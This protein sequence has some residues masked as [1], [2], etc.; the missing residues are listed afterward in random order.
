[1]NNALYDGIPVSIE[2]SSSAP[3]YAN[4]NAENTTGQRYGNHT[5]GKKRKKIRS[6]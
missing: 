4:K 3:D 5:N 2:L 6:W 1:M